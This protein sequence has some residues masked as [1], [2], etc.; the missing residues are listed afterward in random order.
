[1]CVRTTSS[2]EVDAQ[3]NKINGR[4][5]VGQMKYYFVYKKKEISVSY[6]TRRVVDIIEYFGAQ[7]FHLFSP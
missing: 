3:L 2:V 1:M 5:V 6:T 4:S 7:L